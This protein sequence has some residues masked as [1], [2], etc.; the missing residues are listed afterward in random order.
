VFPFNAFALGRDSLIEDYSVV[1]NSFGPIVIGDSVLVGMFNVII[2]PV[3]IGNS[4]MIAPHVVISGLNHGYEDI[5]LP[6][7]EQQCTGSEVVIEDEVW[8]GASAVIT[9]GVRVGKHAV[10]AAGS[11]VTKDVHPYSV[12]AGNPARMIR[13]FDAASGRWERTGEENQSDRAA[14]QPISGSD[15]Q[16]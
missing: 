3:A 14:E 1:N 13:L 16:R 11:V 5:A 6:M 4:V 8:I 7:T 15:V 10:V 2:G 12:V 9:A